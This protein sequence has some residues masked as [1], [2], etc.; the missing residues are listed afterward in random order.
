[1]HGDFR[2]S[3]RGCEPM[4]DNV[5][6]YAPDTPNVGW[7]AGPFCD[8]GCPPL[9]DNDAGDAGIFPTK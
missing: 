9:F 3:E 4:S 6:P 2:T 5:R 8:M 7:D 1:M